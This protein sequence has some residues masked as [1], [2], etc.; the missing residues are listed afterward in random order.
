MMTHKHNWPRWIAHRGAGHL[1]PENTLAAIRL[2]YSKGWRMFEV[3]I[4]LTSDHQPVLMHD[5]TLRRTT[6]LDQHVADTSSSDLRTLDAGR[7]HSPLYA[8][9]PVPSLAQVARFCLANACWINLEIKPAAG[10]AEVTGREVAR[11]TQAL[12]STRATNRCAPMPL[13]TSFEPAALE[14]ARAIAPE[15]PR[16]LLIDT[17][18]TDWVTTLRVLG[19]QVLVCDHT[20]ITPELLQHTRGLG[21]HCLAYTVNNPKRAQQLLE[22]GVRSIITDALDV[23]NTIPNKFTGS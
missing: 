15:I 23:M 9:E 18:E 22:W 3:D 13:F 11:A 12:W 17:L 7:W 16:G 8:G 21:V 4:T 10:L 1:A 5:E 14:S 19:A 6:G 2:G 20:L